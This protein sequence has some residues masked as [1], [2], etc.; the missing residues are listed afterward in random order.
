MNSS[1]TPDGSLPRDYHLG[2]CSGKRGRNSLDVLDLK[3]N[4]WERGRAMILGAWLTIDGRECHAL[5]GRRGK[6]KLKKKRRK[7][8]KI[9]LTE[10]LL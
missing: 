3:R 1:E 8:Q 4:L 10:K 2:T 5:K 6:K 7:M 9:G